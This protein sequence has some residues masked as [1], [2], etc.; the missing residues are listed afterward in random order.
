M[1]GIKLSGE[2]EL[3]NDD[4]RF[5]IDSIDSGTIV[6]EL[7]Y[8][9]ARR[10]QQYRPLK[11]RTILSVD[12]SIPAWAETYETQMVKGFGERARPMGKLGRRGTAP[13]VL[14]T[15]TTYRLWDF[16]TGYEVKDKD[17]QRAGATGINIQSIAMTVNAR[18]AEEH[19]DQIAAV[20]D[21]ADGLVIPGLA[22]CSDV[23]GENSL[24]YLDPVDKVASG[25]ASYGWAVPTNASVDAVNAMIQGMSRDI[26]KL[27]NQIETQ[28]KQI[29]TCDTVVIPN[30]WLAAAQQTIHLYTGRNALSYIR[31]ANPQVQRII[32][33]QQLE[34]AGH[35][36]IGDTAYWK[37]AVGFDS[38]AEEVARM[39]IPRELF[40]DT[41]QRLA[42]GFGI[43][44]PQMYSVG[45]VCIEMPCGIAYLDSAI[46]GT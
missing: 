20:G 30:T 37:R 25:G 39:I 46:H 44:V 29:Y 16:V 28:S 21:T 18:A 23:V 36:N 27:V 8:L 35:R 45:G 24:T 13:S 17:L 40:D 5:T 15:T 1:P 4:I 32:G 11:F 33:W 7:T 2:R 14:K 34:T 10:Q 31:D 26:S 22:N 12:S 38:R 42:E 41:P 19:L 9:R 3:R 43:Y 6:R